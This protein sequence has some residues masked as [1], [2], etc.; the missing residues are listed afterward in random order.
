MVRTGMMDW[1]QVADRM[2]TR[3]AAIG[4]VTG[5]G[6]PIAVGEPANLALVDPE[7]TWIVDPAKSASRSRNTP[8]RGLTLPGRVR[9]TF[10]HG[11]P[12]VLDGRLA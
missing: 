11:R 1:E 10:L 3:P 2:A 5:Q 12:T 9:A 8:F 6:R 7:A 4:R